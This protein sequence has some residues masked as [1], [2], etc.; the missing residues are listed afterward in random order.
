[1]YCKN[2]GNEI[3]ENENFCGKCGQKVDVEDTS[4]NTNVIK[5]KFNYIIYAIITI[6]I[7]AGIVAFMQSI[8]TKPENVNVSNKLYKS[9]TKTVTEWKY[10]EK[11]TI[12][13]GN[14]ELHIGDYVNYDEQTNAKQIEYT[15]PE[16][17]NGYGDQMSFRYRKFT[18]FIGIR[19]C[20]R[21]NTRI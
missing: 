19:R 11:G 3:K 20:Y 18:T 16:S 7:I 1:M 9:N 17:K 8:K 4:N 15:S 21:C 5:I 10:T 6:I 14:I 2:C 12:T 13:D